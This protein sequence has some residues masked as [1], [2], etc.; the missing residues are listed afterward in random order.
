MITAHSMTVDS[1]TDRSHSMQ[2]LT[3][4]FSLGRSAV[5]N[6]VKEDGK[7]CE[8]KNFLKFTRA[9]IKNPSFDQLGLLVG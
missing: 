7:I 2:N 5:S 4:Y 8:S 1:H 3:S 9:R 6:D